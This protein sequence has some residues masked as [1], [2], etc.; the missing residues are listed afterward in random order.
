MAFT[1]SNFEPFLG[2]PRTSTF[3]GC[4][5]LWVFFKIQKECSLDI[6]SY[7]MFYG[8]ILSYDIQV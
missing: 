5:K 6:P 1:I 4:L 2:N 3:S 7:V 8:P